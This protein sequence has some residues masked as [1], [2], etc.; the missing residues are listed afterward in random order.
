[1]RSTVDRLISAGGLLLAIVLLIAGGLLL[2]ANV[3]I[4]NLVHDQLVAQ[5]ITMPTD[6]TG[7]ANLPARTR[8]RWSRTPGSR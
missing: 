7:L 8:R 4:G 6:E 5:K 1:M 2:Y 3:F